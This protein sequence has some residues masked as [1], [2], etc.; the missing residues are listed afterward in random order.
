ML[1]VVLSLVL[2]DATVFITSVL[3]GAQEPQQW[4][5]GQGAEAGGGVWRT[6][7]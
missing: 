5:L 2:S 1:C 4:F 6:S 7:L 3:G